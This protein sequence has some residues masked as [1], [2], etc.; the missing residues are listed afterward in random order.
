[1]STKNLITSAIILVLIASILIVANILGQK[2]P[3]EKATL[4]FPEATKDLASITVSQGQESC[5]LYKKEDRWLVTST[6]GAQN[7]VSAPL[8]NSPTA[9][10]KGYLADSAS[11]AIAVEKISTMK[12]N[13]LISENPS[14]QSLFEVDSSAMQVEI[15]DP[16]GKSL[17]SF[18]IGKNSFTD[19]S[20]NY[21]RMNGSNKVYAVPGELKSSIFMSEKQWRDKSMLKFDKSIV[22]RLII[23]KQA[24]NIIEI[25]QRSDS[26]GSSWQMVRP[27]TSKT[28]TEEVENVLAA[29]GTLKALDWAED[30]ALTD[31]IMGFLKPELVALVTL[32]NGD[33]KSLTIGTTKS[34]SKDFYVRSSEHPGITFTLN[35]YTVATFDKKP[36]D[37]IATDST[38]TS[39]TK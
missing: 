11:V 20:S 13:M 30:P 3:A 10:D 25:A 2:K 35:D 33:E 18:R 31:S 15:F 23:Q 19:W 14:K 37:L 38:S 8:A 24:G 9:M 17:G 16:S 4:F 29:L 6:K 7:T 26:S 21:V 1:M 36:G 22:S 5:R 39:V 12:K 32:K 28:K 27:S 34:D